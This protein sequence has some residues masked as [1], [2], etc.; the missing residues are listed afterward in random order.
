MGKEAANGL[1][2]ISVLLI[3]VVSFGGF[4]IAKSFQIEW[5]QNFAGFT[6]LL[7]MLLLCGT[8][9]LR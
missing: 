2:A 1:I 4:A 5:L 3:L 6:M 9:G 7:S 8:A